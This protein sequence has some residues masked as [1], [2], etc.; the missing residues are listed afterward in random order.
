M[1]NSI[2][3]YLKE[4][5][6]ANVAQL[7]NTDACINISNVSYKKVCDT[8]PNAKETI[9]LVVED[10]NQDP[11]YCT[12][13][14]H[15][16]MTTFG[17]CF[18][19]EEAYEELEELIRSG[20]DPEKYD[21]RYSSARVVKLES[22]GSRGRTLISIGSTCKGCPDVKT[23]EFAWDPYNTDGDCLADK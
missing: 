10:N 11:Q 19:A 7:I 15:I 20:A 17:D 12:D 18:L 5:G 21:H 2:A 16:L 1:K 6:V 22:E 4:S 13:L 3:N 14:M 23:C 8:I 9:Q